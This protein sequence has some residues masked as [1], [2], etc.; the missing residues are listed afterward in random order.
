MRRLII[1]WWSRST[2]N[3]RVT[4]DSR[5]QEGAVR[6]ETA[7]PRQHQPLHWSVYCARPRVYSD[8]VLLA[9][10]PQGT[11]LLTYLLILPYH[12]ECSSCWVDATWRTFSCYCSRTRLTSL[13]II[14]I[15]PGDSLLGI[16]FG[17]VCFVCLQQCLFVSKIMRKQLSCRHEALRIDWQFDR[18]FSLSENNKKVI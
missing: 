17:C 4:G 3:V 2:A 14:S 6:D 12:S 13:S 18:I 15:S 10:Q 8:A 1:L 16:D 11:C 5:R 7:Q 9:R